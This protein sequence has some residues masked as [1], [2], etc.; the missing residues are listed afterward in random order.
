[1]A[2]SL[3]LSEKKYFVSISIQEA[4][5]LNSSVYNVHGMFVTGLSPNYGLLEF[6]HK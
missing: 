2:S 5:I 4:R 1:M 6:L 3:T